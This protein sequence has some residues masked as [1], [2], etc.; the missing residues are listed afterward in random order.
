MS[1]EKLVRDKIP[2][3][4][5][6]KGEEPLVRTASADEIKKLLLQ[7]LSE[8]VAEIQADLNVEEL[9][10]AIEVIYALAQQLNVSLEELEK[11]RI[12]KKEERG[13][14]ENGFVLQLP[15]PTR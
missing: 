12:K 14:F 10:D 4:I 8:E 2:L 9:A 5:R 7:K 11:V 13:G 15:H 1:T 6:S 3:I